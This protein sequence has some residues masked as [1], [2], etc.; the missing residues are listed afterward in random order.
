M[1]GCCP[2]VPPSTAIGAAF[3]E[4]SGPESDMRPG[5]TVE[6]YMARGGN[7]TGLQDDATGNVNDKIENASIPIVR[8]PTSASVDVQFRLTKGSTHETESTLAWTIDTLPPG[9]TLTTSGHLSGTFSDLTAKYK[10][11]IT[12]AWSGGTL[13]V[14]GYTVAPSAGGEGTEIQLISPLPGSIVNSKF[15]PRMHPIQKVMKMHTGIDMKYADRAV[16]DCLAAADG[17]V[18]LAG[19]NPGTGYG[20]RV[21]VKHLSG[22][23]KHL[24]TTTYNHLAK[25][26]VQEGQKVMA[27]QKIGLEGSTGASTGNHL[28]FE[29]KL[30]DGKFID[31]EPLI[32]G[33]LD[34]ARSTLP[35]GDGADVE[36]RTSTASLGEA[37]VQARQESCEPFGPAYPAALPPETT[38]PANPAPPTNDPFELAWF[39]TMTAE[40]GPHWS[41]SSA[42]DPDVIAGLIGTSAQRNKVGYVN[43]ENFPGGE[44]KFGIAQKPNPRTV[45]RT[46][47]YAGA[48]KTGFNNYWKGS[49][50]PSTG[51]LLTN[52]PLVSVMLFDINFHHGG[53]NG[54]KIFNDAGLAISGVQSQA[55]Q[56]A[57]CV[58][59]NTARL[60]FIKKL[61]R[62]A[63]FPGWT[64]RANNCLA[65]CQSLPAL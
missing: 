43:I 58:Q 30:P 28:H 6:C 41:A 2:P 38:D 29:C 61:A 47:D 56:Q 55:Q 27:G 13:D 20:V 64:T 5:E 42:S 11:K 54:R 10:I 44:T 8:T 40:V 62:L 32:R 9:L 23:G 24:C 36:T 1:A 50:I 15:G 45:V 49:P 3:S 16:K 33:S 48:K 18:M 25:V 34:V 39:F 51:T 63:D 17:T 57:M 26:Y 53:G 22:A 31:P 14:R 65:Y 59:L 35:N 19:G 7:T 46:V 52:A 4:A 60:N 21:W 37:E 12:V